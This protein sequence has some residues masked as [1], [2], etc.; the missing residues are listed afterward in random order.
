MIH[1][2]DALYGGIGTRST[3]VRIAVC[4]KH[5]P[6][7]PLRLAPSSLRVDRGGDNELNRRDRSAVEAA[8]RLRDAGIATEVVLLSLGPADAI[9]SLRDGLAMGADRGV[10]CA[11]P[12][13]AGSDLLATSRVLAALVERERPT[14]TLFGQLA[15]DSEG[16]VLPAAVARRLDA[17]VLTQATEL[18]V[19]GRVAVIRRESESGAEQVKTELP[20][21][22]SVTDALAARFPTFA[23][24][25][26]AR[27]KMVDIVDLDQLGVPA[28]LAGEAGSATIVAAATEAPRSRRQAVLVEDDGAA[29]ERIIE[30][31][32]ARS[33]V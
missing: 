25:K 21:V 33:L 18:A 29:P 1:E 32:A 28:E 6:A 22:V 14:L 11:D 19:R 12:R 13:A 27:T 16:G 8:L 31:L 3:P 23:E 7:G 24:V 17:P 10:L 5:V 20:C 30:Y 26:Q 15:S 2:K 4:A 9:V